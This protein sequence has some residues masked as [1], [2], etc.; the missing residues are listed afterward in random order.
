MMSRSAVVAALLGCVPAARVNRK[1][2]TSSNRIG[3]VPVFGEASSSVTEQYL[4]HFTPK[5]TDSMLED[6]CAGN[7]AF[8]GHPDAGGVP[9]VVMKNEKTMAATVFANQFFVQSVE[10]DGEMEDDEVSEEMESSAPWGLDRVGVTR[11]RGTGLGVNIYVLDSGVRV[12][13]VDFAP[14]RAIPTLNA[15]TLPPRECPDADA[16]CVSDNRG[17]GSHVAGSAAGNT[18]GTA[19]GATIRAMN[20]GRSRADG[21]ASM[22]WVAV[23]NIKPAV[24]TMSFGGGGQAAGAEAAV[25]AVVNN[26]VTVTVSAG[27]NN[28]DA[29]QKTFAFIPSAIVVGASDS[30]DSRSSFSNYGECVHIFAPGSR[31]LSADYRSD[32]EGRTISGTSMAT[33]YVAGGAAVILELEPD[34]SPEKVRARLLASAEQDVLADVMGS[35]NLLLNI[36]A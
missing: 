11:A 4:V 24:L 26:G 12:S 17:H 28:Y 14:N 21:Y 32:T 19:P 6:F 1:R 8:M 30:L 5:T 15:L 7:C 22:D 34:L 23:N 20:R 35:P 16:N 10:H 2:E 31:I 13:H 27:N 18:Y 36:G 9:F 33:P 29:C 25:D 3:Q